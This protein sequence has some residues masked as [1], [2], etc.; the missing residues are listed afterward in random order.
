[1]TVIQPL[2]VMIVCPI[3][4]FAIKYKFSDK[5]TKFKANKRAGFLFGFQ[6]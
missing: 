2:C 3:E 4:V 6:S 5:W 1:M